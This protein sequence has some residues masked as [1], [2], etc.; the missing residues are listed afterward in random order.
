MMF[1]DFR[2]IKTQAKWLVYID[3]ISDRKKSWIY[4]ISI[5]FLVMGDI[6]Y[7]Y[8]VMWNLYAISTILR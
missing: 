8:A 3:D 6:C 5:A 2:C 4:A 1:A 7:L